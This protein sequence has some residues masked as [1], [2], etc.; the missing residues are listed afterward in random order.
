MS[1]EELKPKGFFLKMDWD[2]LFNDLDDASVGKMIKNA[3]NYLNNREQIEM[4]KIESVLFKHTI[5]PVLK[6]NVEKYNKQVEHNRS[7]AHLG[8]K[9]SNNNETQI[10]PVGINRSQNI[11]VGIN[12]TPINPSGLST[13][14]ENPKD[15]ERDKVKD[16]EI[17]KERVRD[18][19]RE[20][21]KS[22]D[23]AN[24]KITNKEKEALE[25][26]REFNTIFGEV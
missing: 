4:D 8:G 3:Y 22:R 11:P 17:E 6:F 15:K 1:K 20:N 21:T 5:S 13:I 2:E 16:R 24:S 7:V 10:S 19:E 25:R 14:P 23:K 9:P 18:T 26:V 12:E